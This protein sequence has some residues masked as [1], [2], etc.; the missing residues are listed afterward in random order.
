MALSFAQMLF[1]L[2]WCCLSTVLGQ[3]WCTQTEECAGEDLS[4]DMFYCWGMSS[5][6]VSKLEGSLV[7]CAGFVGC[8]ASDLSMSDDVFCESEDSCAFSSVTTTG[9]NVYCGGYYGCAGVSINC[10][11]GIVECPGEAACRYGEIVKA[12]DGTYCFGDYGCWYTEISGSPVVYS[13]RYR[14]SYMGYISSSG[15]DSM[16][17][18]FGGFYAAYFASISCESGTNCT[19]SCDQSTSCYGLTV[20]CYGDCSISC[21]DGY[22][23]PTVYHF[24]NDDTDMQIKNKWDQ[25]KESKRLIIK[26]HKQQFNTF[27]K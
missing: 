6:A 4:E 3:L 15:V 27:H 11:D 16:Q 25:E 23:C 17:I 8:Y 19:I 9:G 21:D 24:N 10:T 7:D 13:W 12:G 5:C 2:S 22:D 1:V 18:L 20:Y 14:S 26:N